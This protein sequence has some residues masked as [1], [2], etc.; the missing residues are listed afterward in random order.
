MRGSARKSEKVKSGDIIS[1]EKLKELMHD[2]FIP[3]LS[4]AFISPPS[5]EGSL[6]SGVEISDEE[7]AKSAFGQGSRTARR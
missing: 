5:S 4:V 7:M 3:G 6:R 2:A 1:N